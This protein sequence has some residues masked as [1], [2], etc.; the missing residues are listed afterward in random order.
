MT[1][2]LKARRVWALVA[3]FCVGGVEAIADAIPDIVQTPLL[4]VLGAAVAYFSFNP[5]QEY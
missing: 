4:A 5:S 2:Y 1:K 3:M